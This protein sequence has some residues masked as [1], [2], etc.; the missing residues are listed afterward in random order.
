MKADDLLTGDMPSSSSDSGGLDE[1]PMILVE[2][3][4]I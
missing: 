1:E 4:E 3:L 2:V